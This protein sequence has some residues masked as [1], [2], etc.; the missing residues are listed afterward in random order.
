MAARHEAFR[1]SFEM[2]DG[3]PLQR[4]AADVR[5]P[6]EIRDLGGSDDESARTARWMRALSE[7]A[8]RPFDLTRAPLLRATLLRLGADDHVFVLIRHHIIND[9][10]SND[11]FNGELGLLYHTLRR[12]AP[13]G[14]TPPPIQY[15][16]FAEWQRRSLASPE[17]ERQRRYWTGALADAPAVLDLPAD[18]PRPPVQSF[19]GAL[20]S[21][22]ISGPVLAELDALAR[23]S[24]ASNFMVLL[25]AFN[26]LL[27]RYT[28]RDDV[29]VGTPIANRPPE[30]DAVIGFFVNTLALRMRIDP[31]A[32]FSDVVA[33]AR[34]VT[35]DAFD[36]AELPFEHL[37]EAL[38]PE[39]NLSHTPIVNIFFVMQSGYETALILDGVMVKPVEFERTTAKFDLTLFV[40]NDADCLTCT[41]EYN[42]DL[43]D[44]S[45]IERMLGHFET[46]LHAVACE[47]DRPIAHV[48]LSD[49]AERKRIAAWST[50]PAGAVNADDVGV[51]VLVERAAARSPHA[52]AVRYAG[53][54]T[55]YAELMAKADR[56][57]R[58]LHAAGVRGNVPVGLCVDRSADMV[59]AML[60]ILKAGAAYVPLDAGYPRERLAA[61][62]AHLA[63]IVSERRCAA[64]L[65]GGLAVVWLDDDADAPAFD[66]PEHA[67]RAADLAYVMYTSGSTGRP[68]GVAMPHRSLRN[69]VEWQRQRAP[70]IEAPR[71]LAFASLSFDVSFQEIF[72]TL[73]AGG[74]L[75]IA[76]EEMR[77]D[78]GAVLDLV[79]SE[80]VQRLFLPFVVLAQFVD[81]AL[82]ANTI[83]RDVQHVVTA[84]EQ[85]KVTDTLRAFFAQLPQCVVENQYGPTETHVVTAHALTG[86]SE[87]WPP[88][89]PIGRPITNAHLL[90][91]DAYREPVPVGIPGELYVGGCVLAHG[92]LGSDDLTAERFVCDPALQNQ[93]LYRTGDL[94]RWRED[95]EL[96]YLGRLD[97]QVKI[98]GFR[99]EL[100]EV[101]TALR[102][103]PD[104]QDGAV[105]V[106]T[107][108]DG[109]PQLVAYV[110][111]SADAARPPDV[112]AALA[113]VLP[114]HMLP[115]AV[116]EVTAFPFTRNGKLDVEALPAPHASAPA[117]RCRPVESPLTLQLIEIWRS[118]LGLA[119]IA[120]EDNFFA[121]GGHSLLAVKLMSRIHETFGRRLPVATLFHEPTVDALAARLRDEANRDAAER[122]ITVRADGMRAPLFF[123]HGDLNGGGY[124]C[125]GLDR[126]LDR[127]RPLYVFTPHGADGETVPPTFEA[128][129]AENI[130]VLKAARPQGPYVLGGFCSGGLL[131]YE[132][133]RQLTRAGDTVEGVLLVDSAGRNARLAGFG[134]AIER[135][136]RAL[137]LPP[138]AHLPLIAFA[139]NRMRALLAFAE[140]TTAGRRDEIER[141]LR[142]AAA[143]VIQRLD[144]TAA[145]AAIE[146]ERV[147]R[148]ADSDPLVSL[149]QKRSAGYVPGYY[150]G[151]VTVFWPA[152]KEPALQRRLTSH[153][154][155]VARRVNAITITGDHLSCITLDVADLGP[156]F[157]GVLRECPC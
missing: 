27:F 63:V 4:I 96:E 52:V 31:T 104:I 116:V 72:S 43:F 58:R 2:V 44:A 154:A 145:A 12:G 147:K 82:I 83:P 89:P 36:N 121:L 99:I 5:I 70:A 74:T 112:R 106:R 56:I 81:V 13:H 132:M 88:L 35:L 11:L 117:L 18:R 152:S 38:H 87:Q 100:A 90:V 92:Y 48:G 144:S 129:A 34:D 64:R 1:T 113:G 73:A 66:T 128:M 94:V 80:R 17:L 28:G 53:R 77:R 150:A 47:P 45:T 142:S 49:A 50:G 111:P 68:K 39:R 102:A 153:W 125:R 127:D 32:G 55:S 98:R 156:K 51:H 138:D 9:A 114:E 109:S 119:I 91:L 103:L 135:L 76:G 37:V 61:M 15:A 148:E 33:R 115:A 62:T 93:R 85:L 3:E 97:R 78:L 71:T 29:V 146:A 110:V 6:L 67:E 118:L 134:S 65:P 23:R 26:V 24:R 141:W 7:E 30:L 21:R 16:D 42:S 14:L 8:D 46:L 120:P 40:R 19:N 123:L 57:A 75:V 69:L 107:S 22:R 95:G 151:D 133:A 20:A 108:S 126:Y 122:L 86:A 139:A 84:G 25:A 157:N 10:T 60:G 131:A 54:S 143:F 79:V 105:V 140:E 130:A 101:E 155:A 124:Y 59:V 137:R 41:F 149:W 136:A